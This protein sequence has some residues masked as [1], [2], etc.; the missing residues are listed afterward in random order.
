MGDRRGGG[1][2]TRLYCRKSAG[3]EDG[4]TE[5]GVTALPDKSNNS[6]VSPVSVQ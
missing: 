6:R 3:R 4:I 1:R 2:R 5:A